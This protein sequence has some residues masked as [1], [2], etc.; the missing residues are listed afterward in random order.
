[1]SPLKS[2]WELAS[3][4]VI[5]SR[6]R[7]ER[8]DQPLD[9][10]VIPE[11]SDREDRV[12]ESNESHLITD[13]DK[14][15]EKKVSNIKIQDPQ[16]IVVSDKIMEVIWQGQF[17]DYGG[18]ARMNRTMAFGLS[19]RNVKVKVEMD[20]FL[21]HV[22][23][24]TQEQLNNMTRYEVSKTAPKVYGVT[25]PMR[26][27]YPG[28]KILY[29]MI[30][31]SEC[32]HPDYAGKLSMVDEVWVASKYGRDIMEKSN[33]KMPVYVM[34]LGVDINR[35]KPNCGKMDFG[36]TRKFV[37]LSVFRWS[38][39][40][41]FDVLLKAFMEEFS[42]EEDVS[43]LM[44]SRA[45]E[46]PEE[47]SIAKIA[48]DFA[49]VRSFIKKSDDELPHVAL[50][51]KPIHEK[52][53]PKVYGSSDAFVLISR[54]EGFCLPMVEAA[55]CGLPVIASNVTAQRDF[56]KEDNSYLVEPEGYVEAKLN[57]NTAQMA[58]LCRFYEGQRFPD[59]GRRAIEQTREHMRYVYENYQSAKTKAEKLRNLVV[60]NYTWDMAIDRVYNRLKEIYND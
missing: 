37:F 26:V 2:A 30:E 40:K 48:E 32:V 6:Y 24:A 42:G 54:G 14:E 3:E 31:S 56:L 20:T 1:M 12:V 13:P 45:V 17:F 49:S 33:I 5:A 50:Y 58:K 35:Y 9:F 55:S 36:S 59:F 51:T 28:R 29:T 41:G 23:K 39:R 21:T 27:S 22:N 43:L 16:S 11:F 38:Y 60:N 19:N 57:S 7:V 47:N 52:D 10:V 44:V 4:R 25:V 53:M 18:F 15:R 8:E 34:P 46:C